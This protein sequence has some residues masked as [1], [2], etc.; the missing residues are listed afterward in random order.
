MS[1]GCHTS[2]GARSSAKVSAARMAGDVGSPPRRWSGQAGKVS[3]VT[4]KV[5]V[6]AATLDGLYQNG[7]DYSA[8]LPIRRTD[9]PARRFVVQE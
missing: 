4:S 9:Q 6:V 2:P 5:G 1:D 3:A 7:M 8:G